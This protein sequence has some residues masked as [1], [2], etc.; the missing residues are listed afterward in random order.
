M[1]EQ[2]QEKT[3]LLEIYKIHAA[4][5]DNVSRRREMA[6]RT[7]LGA[8]TAIGAAMAL[9]TGLEGGPMWGAGLGLAIL[10][11]LVQMGWKGVIQSHKQLNEHKCNT[12]LE[13]EKQLPFDFYQKEWESMKKGE[14][15]KVYLQTTIAEKRLPSILL[16]AFALA[17]VGFAAYGIS[18]L[19]GS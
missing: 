5:V 9:V 1:N 4:A 7:Y 14:E 2:S 12:L 17:A 6:N 13:L 3:Q 16:M 19:C 10:G 8:T 15:P 18:G 11:G